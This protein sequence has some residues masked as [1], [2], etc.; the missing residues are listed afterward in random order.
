ME[1]ILTQDIDKVGHK[2]DVVKVKDGYGRNYLI[3][4]GMAMIANAGNIKRLNEYKR[5]EEYREN[6]KVDQYRVVAAQLEGKELV[7]KMKA[8]EN[9]R[10]FGSVGTAQIAEGLK[11]QF[12]IVLERR[13]IGMLD[14]KELGKYTA[15]LNFH[16]TIQTKLNFTIEAEAE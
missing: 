13:K 6:K 15:D 11:S 4:K 10:L 16:P 9:G 8:G 14:I 1:V 7:L 12:G 3:P 2:N 5:Q